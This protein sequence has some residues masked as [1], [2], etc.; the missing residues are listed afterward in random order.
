MKKVKVL[1]AALLSITVVLGCAVPTYAASADVTIEV[2]AT[3]MDKVS[4]DVP[5]ILPI[6]FNEDGSN[7]LPTNWTIENK[8][9]IA[10]LHLSRVD[11]D[12][13]TSDW[14][15]LAETVNTKELPADTKSIKFSLGTDEVFKTVVPTEG[16]E[17]ATGS[18]TFED[19][20]ISLPSGS[21]KD[22]VFEVGRGAFNSSEA[23]AKAFDMVLKFEFN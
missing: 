16:T 18:V 15:L 2:K 11:M 22:L 12:A 9:P 17:H 3:T 14:K 10:G 23:L 7:T 8:S 5:G 1:L 6:V 21:H 20:E 13:Q 4:V 19:D